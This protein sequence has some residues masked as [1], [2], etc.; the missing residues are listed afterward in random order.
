M[1]V[2]LDID[3]VLNRVG[4]GKGGDI[5]SSC[6]KVLAEIVKS[7]KADIVLTTSWRTGFSRSVDKCEPVIRNLVY[8]LDKYG[9]TIR[10]RTPK[11]STRTDEI[12]AYLNYTG[13]KRYIIL[14]DDASLFTDKSHLYLVNP[15]TGLTDKDIKKVINFSKGI[16]V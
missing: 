7:L 12:N 4:R 13:E 11:G 10:S 3:G 14:D 16:N 8:E 9:V 15:S 5:V 2:F 6:V 1:I